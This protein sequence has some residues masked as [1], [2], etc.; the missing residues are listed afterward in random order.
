[1]SGARRSIPNGALRSG[2]GVRDNT[3]I[4]FQSDNGGTRVVAFV[5]WPGRAAHFF[6]GHVWGS[7]A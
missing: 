5:N 7:Q 3:I 6:H 2:D 4:V 1:V